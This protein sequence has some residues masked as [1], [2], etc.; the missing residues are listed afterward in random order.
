MKRNWP[1]FEKQNELQSISMF[2]CLQ[3]L[4]SEILQSPFED[5]DEE[6]DDEKQV[7]NSK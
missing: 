2:V 6:E 3:D 4:S 5:E 7:Y 1:L